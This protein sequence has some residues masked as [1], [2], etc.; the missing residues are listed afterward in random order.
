MHFGISYTTTFYEG[1]GLSF[2]QI[3]GVLAVLAASN[4]IAEVLFGM[5]ADGKGNKRVLITGLCFQVLSSWAISMAET[6]QEM[7]AASVLTS[8]SWSMTSGTVNSI[9][10]SS[11]SPTETARFNMTC[12]RFSG[13][14]A[15]AGVVIGSKLFEQF[16]IKMVF[17][18]QPITFLIGLGAAIFLVDKH[19]T[20]QLLDK[21]T[22]PAVLRTL[23]V[24]RRDIRWRM[25]LAATISTGAFALLWLIQPDMTDAGFSKSLFG[26]LYLIRAVA[27]T[28][29]S[30]CITR[31]YNRLGDMRTQLLLLVAVSGSAVFASLPLG[32]FSRAGSVALLL[33]TALEFTLVQALM[34]NAVN[35]AVPQHQ[36]TTAQSTYSSLKALFGV[37]VI[38]IGLLQNSLPTD[39]TLA[40]IGC[41][42]LSFGTLCYVKQKHALKERVAA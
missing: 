36:T 21:A 42:V 1:A 6:F 13:A 4:G 30:L 34:T 31:L 41:A 2:V 25:L 5:A 33:A 35:D 24:E 23:F 7:A 15:I 16:D 19:S 12:P 14:G 27:G 29:L 28:A 39:V 20:R 40:T 22:F 10:K 32:H 26:W 11:S 8:I 38:P 37:A 3:F 9:V 18:A 17:Q